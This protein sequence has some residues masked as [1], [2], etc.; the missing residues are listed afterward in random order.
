[1]RF[2][3]LP[4]VA[5]AFAALVV[6]A[7]APSR[8]VVSQDCPLDAACDTDCNRKASDCIDGCEGKFK[9][10]DKARVTCK[11]EC[12]QKRQQCEKSCQ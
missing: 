3:I 7:P 8:A 5:A 12:A 11:F 10:D 1:M 4:V 9:D 2:S 6:A